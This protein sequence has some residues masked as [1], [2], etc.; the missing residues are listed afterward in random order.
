MTYQAFLWHLSPASPLISPHLHGQ[1]CHLAYAALFLPPG[2]SYLAPCLC[3]CLHLGHLPAVPAVGR[4]EGHLGVSISL[5]PS[6]TLLMHVSL[7]LDPQLATMASFHF[8]KPI[9]QG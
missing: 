6:T 9:F 2:S 5:L 3:L 7:V 4:E 1:C 8:L